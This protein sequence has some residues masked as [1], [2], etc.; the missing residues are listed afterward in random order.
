[1]R[2]LTFLVFT[3]TIWAHLLKTSQISAMRAD[4]SIAMGGAG[5]RRRIA[6]S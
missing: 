2:S 5:I 3:R 4:G 1:M 6:L